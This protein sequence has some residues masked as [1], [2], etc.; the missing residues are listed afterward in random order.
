MVLRSSVTLVCVCVCICV[1]VCAY[2]WCRLGYI[3]WVDL[4]SDKIL[5]A[6][7]EDGHNITAII[8]SSLE[9]PSTSRTPTK[10]NCAPTNVHAIYKFA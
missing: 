4:H 9:G 3:Y 7:L 6:D 10:L 8:N 2:V 5:R 1:Y